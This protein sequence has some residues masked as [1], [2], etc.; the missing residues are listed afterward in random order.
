MLSGAN[1]YSGLTAVSDGT[2]RQGAAG[3]FVGNGAYA[4]NGG[5]LDLNNF[6]LTASSLSGT[7]GTVAL[8]SAALTV[9]QASNTRPSTHYRVARF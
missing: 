6:A 8:G 9:D 1:S 7:A 3:A 5:T 2:L 4:V